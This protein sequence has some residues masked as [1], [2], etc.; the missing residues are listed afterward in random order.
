MTGE[1]NTRTPVTFQAVG[2]LLNVVLDPVLIFSAGLG[3][4][5]AAWATVIS[6]ITVLVIF[7]VYIFVRKGSYLNLGSGKFTITR[8]TSKN[9][10]RVG[11]PSSAAMMMMSLGSMFLTA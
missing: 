3:I 9:I 5:G 4:A 8:S 11:M 2:T 6:Q 7:C 1:G 10:L